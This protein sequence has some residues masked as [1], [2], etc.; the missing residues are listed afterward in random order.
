MT[1]QN[2]FMLYKLNKFN[3]KFQ[4]KNKIENMKSMFKQRTFYN[5][6]LNIVSL[7]YSFWFTFGTVQKNINKTY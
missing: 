3:L 6:I 5:R 2:K 7:E 4:N 1:P